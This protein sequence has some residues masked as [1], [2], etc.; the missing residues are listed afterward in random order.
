[1]IKSQLNTSKVKV[2]SLQQLRQV[3]GGRGDVASPMAW[4]TQSNNCGTVGDNEWS[5]Q[6]SGCR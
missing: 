5:T 4:S 6:S 1:M 2:L 3:S